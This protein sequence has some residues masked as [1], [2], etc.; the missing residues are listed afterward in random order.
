MKGTLHHRYINLGQPILYN[1]V[2]EIEL[3]VYFRY[4]ILQLYLIRILYYKYI[5]YG[6]IIYYWYYQRVYY[7]KF[8]L[9]VYI[10]DIY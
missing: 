1:H 4:I 2:A 5:S 9:Y 8:I 6:Y 3:H 10:T 7:I